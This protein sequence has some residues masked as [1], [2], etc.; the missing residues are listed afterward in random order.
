MDLSIV[1]TGY[2]IKN[3]I[4]LAIN[5]LLHFHPEY[6]NK[7]I[8]FDDNSNDGTKEWIYKNNFKYIT[9]SKEYDLSN[10]SETGYRVSC[11]Y[12]EIFDQCKTRYL[13]INDGD[14]VFYD[15][16][17][18][19]YSELIQEYPLLFDI[20]D[21]YSLDVDDN[22]S[23]IDKSHRLWYHNLLLKKYKYDIIYNEY[24][25]SYKRIDPCHFLIDLKYLQDKRINSIDD[26]NDNWKYLSTYPLD[27]GSNFLYKVII[28][29]LK[30]KRIYHNNYIFHIGWM[31][32]MERINTEKMNIN[33]DVSTSKKLFLNRFHKE[34]E[35][36]IKLK[37]MVELYDIR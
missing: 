10:T 12:K 33:Y 2:N 28:N 7:I 8:V 17:K 11:I 32:S 26:I 5:S 25:R 37:Y 23:I 6:R 16:I 22:Q 31:S 15:K 14:I 30:Y 36:N 4:S 34:Q 19:N 35:N 27:L 20:I 1:F 24:T 29:N 13:M 9:W 3:Y 18:H 21:C